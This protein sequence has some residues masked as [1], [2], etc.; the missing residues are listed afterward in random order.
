MDLGV[1][2]DL[3]QRL[4]VGLQRGDDGINLLDGLAASLAGQVAAALREE[5]DRLQPDE[6]VGE[7]GDRVR[8]VLRRQMQGEDEPLAQGDE[9]GEP[10]PGDGAGPGGQAERPRP[11]VVDPQLPGVLLDG[12]G[13]QGRGGRLRCRRA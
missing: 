3:E 10:A 11:L 5:A 7:L 6:H 8:R 4:L 1:E 13:G 9:A 12:V 2:R